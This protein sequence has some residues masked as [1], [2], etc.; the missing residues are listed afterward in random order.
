MTP[1]CG[2]KGG[3]GN[4][5]SHE[6]S[7]DPLP[8][9]PDIHLKTEANPFRGPVPL[10]VK[11]SVEPFKASGDVRYRWRFDDG[12]TSKEQNPVHTFTKPGYYQV[13]VLAEDNKT[14][15][16][17]NLVLSA[18]PKSVWES[19]TKGA[20]A[21]EIRKHVRD[22]ERRTARRR[23]KHPLRAPTHPSQER[24]EQKTED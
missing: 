5:G 12:T 11:F 18:W 23:R 16:A 15:D 1:G 3:D 20:S 21:R 9:N 2:L 13:I 10:K 24:A 4:N 19:T 7:E 22:Q 8:D 14:S 17:W 6:G